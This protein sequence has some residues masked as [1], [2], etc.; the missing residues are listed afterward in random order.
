MVNKVYLVGNAGRDAE[1]KKLENGTSVAG[2]SLAT[3]E[4]YKDKSDEWQ[5][6][7]TWHNIVCWRHLAD[8]A[9]KDV[10]KGTQVYVEGKISV[11]EYTDKDGVVKRVTDIVASQM[12]TFDRQ[13]KTSSLPQEEHSNIA[14]EPKDSLPF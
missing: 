14:T 10:K 9:G 8:K 6:I 4:S 11:R 3:S 1:V 5:T 2:F 13:E 12:L 7:T